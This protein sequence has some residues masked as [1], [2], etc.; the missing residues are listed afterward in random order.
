[1]SRALP[2][3][4]MLSVLVSASAC[5]DRPLHVSG[6]QVGRSLNE[7]NTV[8]KSPRCSPSTD[9][10]YV[11][12]A[13]TDLGAGKLTVKWSA[14]AAA[15]RT[16]ETGVVQDRRRH[17]VPPRERRRIPA[18]SLQRRGA[19]R[20]HVRRHPHL[21]RQVTVGTSGRRPLAI[22]SR[23]DTASRSRS[24]PRSICDNRTR[25]TGWGR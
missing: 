24:A 12:I 18:R 11:S 20:R 2:L 15:E 9:T 17:R 4:L 8:G 22:A 10:V 7:D 6:I 25:T 3:G 14:T 21:H 1:M 16:L 19:A 5:A 23:R 13:T